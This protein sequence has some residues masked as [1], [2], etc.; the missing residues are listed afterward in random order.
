MEKEERRERK[1]EAS[2]F[3]TKLSEKLKK[4][5]HFTFHIICLPSR[6]CQSAMMEHAV[7]LCESRKLPAHLT[8]PQN[9][10]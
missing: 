6:H 1:E 7:F 8:G 5:L 4:N 2:L 10:N 9:K 3:K